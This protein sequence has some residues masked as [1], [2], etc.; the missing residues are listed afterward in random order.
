MR[1]KAAN[2]V[3]Y[4]RASRSSG[5][6]AREIPMC[7]AAVC[8][9]PVRTVLLGSWAAGHTLIDI[10]IWYLPLLF[11]VGKSLPLSFN[12]GTS[13]RAFTYIIFSPLT[14]Q[15]LCL[16]YDVTSNG[17]LFNSSLNC[18]FDLTMSI[19]LPFPSMICR[20]AQGT[21]YSPILLH[22][23]TLFPSCLSCISFRLPW[24]THMP[25]LH[26]TLYLHRTAGR[27]THSMHESGLSSPL[28]PVGAMLRT[29]MQTSV[30]PM[31]QPWCEYLSVPRAVSSTAWLDATS[32]GLKRAISKPTR[33]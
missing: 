6:L 12:S 7:L 22:Q 30:Y 31:A 9:V 21:S 17:V 8:L 19:Y 27:P 33:I 4:R 11:P 25:C 24:F 18:F 5:S 28:S 1:H 26:R 20:D 14:I 10:I 13:Y 29:L 16:T 15:P 32:P 3:G 2:S 23:G